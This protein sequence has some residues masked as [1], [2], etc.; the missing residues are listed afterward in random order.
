MSW[1]IAFLML[2]A[3]SLCPGSLMTTS[4]QGQ[5]TEIKVLQGGD[6]GH[7]SSVEERERARNKIHQIVRNSVIVATFSTTTGS[8][9][10]IPSTTTSATTK[11]TTVSKTTMS[12]TAAITTVPTTTGTYTRANI[13]NGTP[14][15]RRV[16]FINMTDT[17]YN[18]PTGLNLTSYSKRT[19][20][21]SHTTWGG[22]S[23]TTFS[24]G[25]FS[26]SRVCGR[27]R[28]YQ[29]GATSAF[30]PYEYTAKINGYYASGVSLTR[31]VP[32]NRQHIWTFA[33]GLTEIATRL[34]DYACPCDSAAPAVVPAFVGND[35]FCESG[36]HY[37][38]SSSYTGVFFSD[39]V[40]WD[41]Q[42]C[43]TNSTMSCCQFNNPPWFTKNL[44]SATTDDIELRI[45]TPNIPSH[46]DVPLELIELY[47]Q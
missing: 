31:G 35:Y 17:S 46:A 25:D 23:S 13:C 19:C 12:T 43:T 16:A 22:C 26:Y 7:C 8:T 27:I 30:F 3:L 4:G 2:S 18:C 39:D 6:D 24:V 1:T 9:T 33:A 14:G 15:W 11:F 47:V 34:P 21:R 42:D 10:T 40:L 29:F 38:W 41:G 44:T 36:L 28:G 5:V 45:C 37:D 32:S 20:G